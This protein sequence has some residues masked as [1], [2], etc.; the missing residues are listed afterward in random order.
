MSEEGSSTD[1]RDGSGLP[2]GTQMVEKKKATRR[3]DKVSTSYTIFLI[4]MT[5]VFLA[6][7]IV[8]GVN[9]Y[10]YDK[11]RKNGCSSNISSSEAEALYWTNLILAVIS[12]IMFI[13]CI[14]LIFT[15]TKAPLI[16]NTYLHDKRATLERTARNQWDQYYQQGKGNLKNAVGSVYDY[17][18]KYGQ[19]ALLA[20]QG[21]SM[22]ASAGWQRGLIPT[23]DSA[24]TDFNE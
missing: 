5:I 9:T 2:D 7:A 19:A 24:P 14:I 15:T 8:F 21:A 4:V 22:G 11:I 1:F 6:I 12:G 23:S 20:A 17:S 18:K 10:F 13:V 3:H 16:A